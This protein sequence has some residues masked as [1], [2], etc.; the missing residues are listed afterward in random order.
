MPE[1]ININDCVGKSIEGIEFSWNL[2]AVENQ[3]GICVNK[4]IYED[5]RSDSESV[6]L[7]YYDKGI[8]LLFKDGR[9]TTIFLYS[10][11]AYGY[12]TGRFSKYQ[13]HTP[14][15]ISFDSGIDE[16]KNIYGDPTRENPNKYAPIPYTTLSYKGFAFDV[17]LT[18]GKIG[19]II[20]TEG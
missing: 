11:L 12:E 7:N 5:K 9:L 6:Y 16:I 4:K 1:G 14:L 18:D 3:L 17:N 8:S 15:N 19:T 10:G 13:F 2:A 20:I